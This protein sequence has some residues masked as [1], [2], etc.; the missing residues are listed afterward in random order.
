VAR[1]APGVQDEPSE[2]AHSEPVEASGREPGL[3]HETQKEAVGI[4]PPKR[5]AVA[6]ELVQCIVNK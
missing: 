4:A 1:T 6:K 3:G 2:Q 5:E